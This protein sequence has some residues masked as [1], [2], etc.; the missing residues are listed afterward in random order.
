MKITE[1]ALSLK[2]ILESEY[3]RPS[4][5][6][7]LRDYYK[8]K[9]DLPNNVIHP[10]PVEVAI[11]NKNYNAKAYELGYFTTAEGFKIGIYEIDIPANVRLNFN[12]KTLRDLLSIQYKESIEGALVVYNQEASRKWRFTYIQNLNN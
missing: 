11:S 8:F 1:S 12:R 9:N 4:W 6:Q 7:V 10:L 2:K 5:I 3:H